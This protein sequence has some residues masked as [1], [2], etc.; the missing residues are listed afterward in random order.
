MS[1]LG[2]IIL[3]DFQGESF[4]VY[5]VYNFSYIFIDDKNC[6]LLRSIITFLLKI[7]R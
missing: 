6:K 2:R 7:T 1:E 4:C 3:L 5:L